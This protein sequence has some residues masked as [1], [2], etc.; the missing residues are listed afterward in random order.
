[1][2][3]DRSRGCEIVDTFPDFQIFWDEFQRSDIDE[4]LEGYEEAYL[5]RWPELFKLQREGYEE[6]SL[7]W[8]E[9]A[10]ERVL[11]YLK[12]RYPLMVMARKNLLRYI[13]TVYERSIEKLDID[14]PISFVLHVGIGSA[15]WAHFYE[16]KRAVIHGLEMIA[17]EDWIDE[18]SIKGLVAHEIGHHYHLDLREKNDVKVGDDPF[19][20]LYEE[21]IAQRCEHIILEEDNWHMKKIADGWQEYCEANL[22][23]LAGKYLEWIEEGKNTNKFFGNWYDIDGYSMVGYFLGHEV[24][25]QIQKRYE[26]KKISSLSLADMR[27]NVKE[28]LI[29]LSDH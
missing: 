29:E 4:L 14:F 7:N 12:E 21:G 3:L 13:P 24:I 2:A 10:E 17:E 26:L 15:G 28:V 8:K 6:Y 9:V 25:K 5:K 27:A 19:W 20:N 22:G 11:P 23:D 18:R 1:M 16:G